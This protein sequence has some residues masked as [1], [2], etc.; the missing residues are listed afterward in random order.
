[1]PIADVAALREQFRVDLLP[2][3]GHYFI[4]RSRDV[5]LVEVILPEDSRF[6]RKTVAEAEL[7]GHSELT[8]VGVR[9][10]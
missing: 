2:N 8:V 4:D 9:R 6:A 7:L 10:G 3:P 5:G 1:M